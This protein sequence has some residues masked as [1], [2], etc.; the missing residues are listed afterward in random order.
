MKRQTGGKHV[1][2]NPLFHVERRHL[3]TISSLQ[4]DECMHGPGV[5]AS[6]RNSLK[7][8]LSPVCALLKSRKHNRKAHN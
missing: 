3:R 4:T 2:G 1:R 7:D 5:A 8:Q 6:W